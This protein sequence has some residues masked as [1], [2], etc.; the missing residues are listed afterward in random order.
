MAGL[1]RLAGALA[2]VATAC[3][4][5]GVPAAPA[6]R[7]PTGVSS[8]GTSSQPGMYVGTITTIAS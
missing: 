2:V 3:L 4:V 1:C 8:D 5:A 6:S 7:E